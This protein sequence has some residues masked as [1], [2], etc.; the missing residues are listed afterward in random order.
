MSPCNPPCS[1]G[2]TC[3][4]N[5]QCLQSGPAVPAGEVDSGWARGAAITGYILTPIAVGFGIGA[6]A[7][8]DNQG[9]AIGLG[10]ACT[11]IAGVGVPII[12][13]GG[14]SARK[15]PSVSGIPGL[16]VAGWISYGLFMGDAVT[17]IA[18]GAANQNPGPAP[19]IGALSL[20]GF[21][22]MAFAADAMASANKAD[23]LADPQESGSA[24]K[25]ELSPFVVPAPRMLHFNSL[26]SQPQ[27]AL[28]GV[29]GRF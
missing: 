4:A 16:R 1:P 2:Q 25:L 6:A 20:G 11:V 17:L 14:G 21:S 19:I 18:L 29:F 5:G 3:T 23:A 8:T 15:N 27:G 22:L 10:T 24:A 28:V 13:I 7:T 9:T 26:G 12:A